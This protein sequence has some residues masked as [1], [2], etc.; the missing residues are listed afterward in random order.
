MEEKRGQACYIVLAGMG[1][2]QDVD[3]VAAVERYAA[4]AVQDVLNWARRDQAAFRLL[5]GEQGLLPPEKLV[6]LTDQ[7]EIVAAAVPE[8]AARLAEQLREQGWNRLVLYTAKVEKQP[9]LLIA[10]GCLQVAAGI[11]GGVVV[12]HHEL[13]DEK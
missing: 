2:R 6:G 3:E 10:L 1:Q 9:S 12:E 5:S 11:V 8:L 4:E 13:P 7:N